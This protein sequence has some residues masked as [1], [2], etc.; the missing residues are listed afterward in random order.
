ME[1]K[2]S[3]RCRLVPLLRKGS[4]S[5]SRYHEM[6]ARLRELMPRATDFVFLRRRGGL[7]KN[8]QVGVGVLHRS[9]RK[10]VVHDEVA[11][12][13]NFGGLAEEQQAGG[14]ELGD[15]GRAVDVV[16]RRRAGLG[17]RSAPRSGPPV[18]GISTGGRR[19]RGARICRRAAAPELRRRKVTCDI[20]P[21]RH[22][23]ERRVLRGEGVE[24]LVPPVK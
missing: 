24:P 16:A 22:E 2:G 4:T 13:V 19:S 1:W 3:Y 23:F 20:D 15:N 10:S 9:K 18:E 12:R 5:E 17:R 7:L 6:S 21:Q 14:V 8:S 11:K